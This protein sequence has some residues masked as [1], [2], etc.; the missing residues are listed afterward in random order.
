MPGRPK[1]P[2]W[3]WKRDPLVVDAVLMYAQRGHGKRWSYLSNYTFGVWSRGEEGD[4]LVPVGKAYF[5]FTDEELL[6]I[7]QFVRRNTVERFGPVREVVAGRARG[8]YSKWHSKGCNARTDTDQ[9]LP[10]AFLGSIACVGTSLQG[11]PTGWKLSKPCL[12][13]SRP[14]AARKR[15]NPRRDR[16]TTGQ[17]FVGAGQLAPATTRARQCLAPTDTEPDRHNDHAL[18]PAEH[19]EHPAQDR[20]ARNLVNRFFGGPPLSVIFRLVLLSILIGVI[21]EVMGLD[22]W[23]ILDGLAGCSC[24]CGTWASTPYAG[25]GATFFLAPASSCR[26]G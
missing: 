26:F 25:S 5:G 20:R 17:I 24:G 14:G 11:R 7:D 22:P 1:G 9:A 21:L 3:K 12:R 15:Q 6:Q 8:W 13:R 19:R 18:R 2:W 16:I 10:C 4:V 23:N